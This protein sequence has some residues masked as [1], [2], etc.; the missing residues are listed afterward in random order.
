MYSCMLMMPPVG[1]AV[2]PEGV[3]GVAGA[4]AITLEAVD[5]IRTE[6]HL[7]APPGVACLT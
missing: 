6:A 3:M 2:S 5:A 7:A 4:L 1:G